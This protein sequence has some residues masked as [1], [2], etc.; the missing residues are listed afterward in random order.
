M[1]GDIFYTRVQIVNGLFLS[2]PSGW[3]AT[4]SFADRLGKIDISIHALRV[5][6]D[7]PGY[8]PHFS[9]VISIHALRV[10]GDAWLH[11]VQRPPSQNFYPRPPGGGRQSKMYEKSNAPLYFYPRPPGGGRLFTTF[12]TNS[13]PYFYP[14]PPGGGRRWCAQW[15]DVCQYISIHALRVEGDAMRKAS[16]DLLFIFLSTPSG[17]RATYTGRNGGDAYFSISIHALRVEGDPIPRT[18]RRKIRDFYPRPPGGGRP[19]A[20]RTSRSS[21]YFYPRPPGGGRRRP[22]RFPTWPRKFLSTPS[23]WRA[24]LPSASGFLS[25]V[26]FYPRPPGGGRLHADLSQLV[27]QNISIHALRVEGDAAE[28][29]DSVQK[30]DISIHALR[31]EGDHRDNHRRVRPNHFYPRPPGGG[32]PMSAAKIH[33]TA[34]FLSTPSGWRATISCAVSFRVKRFLSTPSGWRAT[35]S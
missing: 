7:S 31:V 23:G 6:G 1:E 25:F 12:Y 5:E 21:T 10:E 24:T 8:A 15:N 27:K 3:R 2:T 20:P 18:V 14:R 13:I 22:Y 17:W 9:D 34:P 35:L 32:R 28:T 16:N 4:I 30:I 29:A 33:T 11:E 26:Y 19:K